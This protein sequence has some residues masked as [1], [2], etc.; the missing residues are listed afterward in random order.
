MLKSALRMGAAAL[1]VGVTLLAGLGR[2]QELVPSTYMQLRYRHIGPEGN[3]VIAIAGH[4]GQPDVIYAGAASG[5][6]WKTT[7]A[8][9]NWTPVFDDTDVSSIGAL[10]V[11]RSDPN[12]VWAGTGET[13]LRS[14]I[15][16]GNGIYRSTDAGASWRHMGLRETGRIGRV[17]IHPDD[18][19]I[20]Y[21]AAVGTAYG[22]QQERGVFRTTDGGESWERVLFVA[23][24]TGASDIA[25][26]P[27]NPRKLVAGMWPIDIK[28]WQRTS[29]GANGGVYL[30]LD[31]GDT[32]ERKTDGL[33]EPPTGKIGLAYAPSNPDRIYALIET[34]QEAFA[35][36]LWRS[37]DGGDSWRLISRDQQYH[38]RPHYYT[39][40]V[41][42][43]DDEDEVYDPNSSKKRGSGPRINVKKNKW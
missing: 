36:V 8:G 29:G 21:A 10:A 7:D 6:V 11:S 12:V 1:A 19:D 20:V 14:M 4:P 5:G 23:P 2:A 17:L 37:E 22:P 18:P 3:R 31:G 42:A 30:S 9:L 26:D 32:W 33:P 43:P 41:V 40:L 13:N 16:I 15:S 25:M 27:S 35:G 39:R 24:D 28:T 38:T 34:D